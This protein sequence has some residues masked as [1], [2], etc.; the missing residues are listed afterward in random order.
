MRARRSK[1]ARVVDVGA[2]GVA[3]RQRP[4]EL[5]SVATGD[6]RLGREKAEVAVYMDTVLVDRLKLAAQI[7]DRQHEAGVKLLTEYAEPAGIVPPVEPAWEPRDRSSRPEC[8]DA[9]DETEPGA[10]DHW[11]RLMRSLPQG[12]ADVLTDMILGRHPGVKWLAT[13]QAALD[14]LAGKWRIVG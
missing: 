1:A 6:V 7:T 12:H 13:L 8:Q 5:A 4:Y 11:N 9:T 14:N 10:R 2:E 3:H